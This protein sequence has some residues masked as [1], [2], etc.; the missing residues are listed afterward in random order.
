V[1]DW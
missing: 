1:S